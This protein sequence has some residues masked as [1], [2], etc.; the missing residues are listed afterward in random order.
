[1]PEPDSVIY[2]DDFLDFTGNRAE[3][4]RDDTG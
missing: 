4:K 3:A 1:M 2:D